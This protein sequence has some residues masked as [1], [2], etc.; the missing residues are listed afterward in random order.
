MKRLVAL[1]LI[2]AVLVPAAGSAAY[3]PA[4]GMTMQEFVDKYNAVQAPLGA[5]YVPLAKPVKWTTYEGSPVACFYPLKD[6]SVLLLLLSN[7]PL[8]ARTTDMGLDNVQIYINEEKY[9]VPFISIS[10]RCANVFSSDM[11]GLDAATYAVGSTI[12]FYY[13]NNLEE[14][15]LTAYN[16]L[17]GDQ[18]YA[19][20][21]FRSDGYYFSIN[22]S[23]VAP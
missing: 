4:L 8:G 9:F 19:L 15:G 5:P 16:V 21:F 17:D 22:P 13:E 1:L 6:F 20:Y 18:K 2:L 10:E 11:F 12:R 3:T 14:R 7:D 23:E